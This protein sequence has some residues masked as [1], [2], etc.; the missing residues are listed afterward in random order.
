MFEQK[1]IYKQIKIYL[2]TIKAKEG[3]GEELLSPFFKIF[4]F[5]VC[6]G[7]DACIFLISFF[8]ASFPACYKLKYSRIALSCGSI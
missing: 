8:L 5:S 3:G 2:G 4:C 6:G 1:M 7:L